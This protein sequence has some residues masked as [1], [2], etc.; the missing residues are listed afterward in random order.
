MPDQVV[1]KVLED[2][3]KVYVWRTDLMAS[4]Q[5]WRE[6]FTGLTDIFLNLNIPKQ[7]LLAGSDRMDKELTIARMQGRFKLVVIDG[8]GH[9]VQEDRPE[10]VADA[11]V[12]FL[13]Q[14]HIPTKFKEQM[15]I[16]TISGKKVKINAGP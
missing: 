13:D 3:N 12:T 4:K 5:Y 9:V 2:G 15:Y 16:T 14:F 10:A 6:W 8:V 1:E 7:L 11:F